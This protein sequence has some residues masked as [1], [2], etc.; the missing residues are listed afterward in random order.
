[1][2]DSRTQEQSTTNAS[3]LPASGICLV[4]KSWVAFGGFFLP[5]LQSSIPL[6]LI[7]PFTVHSHCYLIPWSYSASVFN[8]L[9]PFISTASRP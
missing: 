5:S 4:Y 6:S 1:M 9:R 3:M 7:S 2:R 8:L